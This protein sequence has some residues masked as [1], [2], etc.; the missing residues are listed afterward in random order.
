MYVYDTRPFD[1]DGKTIVKDKEYLGRHLGPAHRVGNRFCAWVVDAT[2]VPKASTGVHPVPQDGLNSFDV[3][4]KIAAIDAS[5]NDKLSGD[6]VVQGIEIDEGKLLE[7]RFLEEDLKNNGD[8]TAK[9]VKPAATMPEADGFTCQ[10][11]YSSEQVLQC[12]H[13]QD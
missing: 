1:K 11:N 12:L 13:L 10:D 6:H 3:Q 8:G 7:S 2:G 9:A 5:I 4:A